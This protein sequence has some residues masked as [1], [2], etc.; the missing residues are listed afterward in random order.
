MCDHV[1]EQEVLGGME[2]MGGGEK[3]GGRGGQGE[4]G[5]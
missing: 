4:T 3:G 1:H 5:I 2:G